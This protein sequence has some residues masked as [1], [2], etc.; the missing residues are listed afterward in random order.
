MFAPLCFEPTGPTILVAAATSASAGVQV[1]HGV[2]QNGAG[3]M[4]YNKGV[5]TAFVA[6]GGSAVSAA[7][8]TATAQPSYPVKPGDYLFIK[9]APNQYVSGIVATTAGSVFVTPGRFREFS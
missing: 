5:D 3:Y 9:A 2:S 7:I 4:F 6:L 1:A 8:P